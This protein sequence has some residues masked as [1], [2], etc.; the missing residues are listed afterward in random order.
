MN[1]KCIATDRRPQP[2]LDSYSRTTAKSPLGGT[3]LRDDIQP[4]F[5][6]LGVLI[7]FKNSAGTLPAVLEALKSQT[8]QPDYILGVDTGSTDAS[9]GLLEAAGAQ[10]VRWWES[11]HHA[12]VLNFGLAHCPAERVLVLSSHTVL[13]SPDAL[14][15]LNAALDDPRVA[16]ASS[17]WDS[18]SYYSDAIAWDELQHKG[19]KI[20]SIYSNSFGLLRRSLWEEVPFDESLVTMEDYD[21]ALTQIRRG[22]LCRR[23]R[24]NFLYQR[25]A[26]SRDY[27]FTAFAFRLAARYGLHVRWLGR[28]A[29]V[30]QLAR[31]H[32]AQLA[33]PLSEPD[34]AQKELLRARLIASIFWRFHHPTSDTPIQSRS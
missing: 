33:H 4:A 32:I 7:R 28:K 11:Y 1:P 9:P 12:R 17:P 30:K 5:V 27:L 19:L 2:G 13:Q 26:N 18:D 25:Q 22:H 16:C 21:W 6:P 3:P 14:E 29:S 20:G 10:I 24:F 34:Y 8:L 31:L 15:Q 23:V